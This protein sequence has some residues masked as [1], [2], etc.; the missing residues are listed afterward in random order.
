MPVT[1]SDSRRALEIVT[2]FYHSSETHEEV[3]FPVTATHPKYRSW[4][5]KEFV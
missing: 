1:S 2:A 3:S 5:P 4:L